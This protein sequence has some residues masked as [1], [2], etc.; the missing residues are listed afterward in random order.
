MTVEQCQ[1]TCASYKYFGVEY[2]KRLLV[3]TYHGI[4][5]TN[6][7]VENAIARTSLIMVECQH[8]ALTAV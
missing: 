4:V 5:L 3:L 7:Q 2:G 6:V 8:L 1:S